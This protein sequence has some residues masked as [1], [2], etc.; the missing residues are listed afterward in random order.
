MHIEVRRNEFCTRKQLNLSRYHA[1]IKFIGYQ[2]QE[3]KSYL[4]PYTGSPIWVQTWC[5]IRTVIQQWSLQYSSMINYTKLFL[6]D[7]LFPCTVIIRYVFNESIY[8][9]CKCISYTILTWKSVQKKKSVHNS[10]ITGGGHN[11]TITVSGD[12]MANGVKLLLYVTLSIHN[13]IMFYNN[14][15]LQYSAMLNYTKLFLT[16]IFF[17]KLQL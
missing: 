7:I 12:V 2:R 14:Q 6:T 15:V 10:K 5:N 9:T 11:R 17:C 1:H 13:W 4:L 3:E 8:Y 16:G